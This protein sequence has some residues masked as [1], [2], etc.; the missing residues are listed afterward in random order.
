MKPRY[1]ISGRPSENR[2]ENPQTGSRPRY[3]AGLKERWQ[4]L[5]W[6]DRALTRVLTL[7]MVAGTFLFLWSASRGRAGTSA[8]GT[9]RALHVLVRGQITSE[10]ENQEDLKVTVS[11]PHIPYQETWTEDVAQAGVDR[12]E[13]RLELHTSR[14]LGEGTVTIEKPGFRPLRLSG[15]SAESSG[16]DSV[17][18]LG[19]L[20]MVKL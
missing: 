7:G 14:P 18:S 10:P 8:Q 6:S 17:F 3:R 13:K 16:K 4:K 9:D 20:T 2:A 1:N 5:R 11:L 15:L 12:F 19:E